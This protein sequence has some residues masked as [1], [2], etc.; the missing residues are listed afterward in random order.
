M[1]HRI[2]SIADICVDIV[3]CVLQ[4]EDRNYPNSYL[5]TLAAL[6][7]VSRSFHDPAVDVLWRGLKSA[8]PLVRLLPP[9]YFAPVNDVWEYIG[10]NTEV[11]THLT[12][13]VQ[14]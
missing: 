9:E 5:G 14:T 2:F 13:V 3:E 1:T 11:R 7:C 10:G 4:P 12:P 6:A 8:L